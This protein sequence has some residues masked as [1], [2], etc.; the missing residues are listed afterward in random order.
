[1]I[2]H[3]GYSKAGSRFFQKNVFP[4]MSGIT[5]YEEKLCWDLFQNTFSSTTFEFDAEVESHKLDGSSTSLYSLQR[6]CGN[7]AKGTYNYE[8][9]LRLKAMGFKKVIIII[10]RQDKMLESLYR[11]YIQQGGVMTATELVEHEFQW[12]WAFLDYLPL[13][14][15]YVNVFGEDN[16]LVFPLEETKKSMHS[17]LDKL[18]YFC[19]CEEIN[20]SAQPEEN[21]NIRGK[22]VINKSLS[23]HSIKLLRIINHFTYNYYRP[24]GILPDS[25]TTEKIRY[26]LKRW[27]DPIINSIFLEKKQFYSDAF[28]EEVLERYKKS[29]KLLSERFDLNLGQYGYFGNT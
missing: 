10:R 5:Y 21:N 23:F 1:M 16:L 11:Q 25:L 28:K 26:F 20:F 4:Y 24:S 6:L 14:S 19:D 29:N 17:V 27:S 9:V 18:K 8:I 3:A 12:S 2:I 13:L 15:H 7:I 22:G